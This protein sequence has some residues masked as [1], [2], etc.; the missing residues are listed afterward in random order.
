M[1]SPPFFNLSETSADFS[2]ALAHDV[3]LYQ[4]EALMLTG[5]S[6]SSNETLYVMYGICAPVGTLYS[7]YAGIL[8]DSQN[9]CIA[10]D[11]FMM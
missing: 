4:I 1:V 11:L 2:V 8:K 9:F 6:S 3:S 7:S 5:E 10:C